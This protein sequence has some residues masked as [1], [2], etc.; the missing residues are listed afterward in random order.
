MGISSSSSAPVHIK[1]KSCIR[2]LEF[3]ILFRPLIQL[4][5]TNLTVMQELDPTGNL[6]LVQILVIA[7]IGMIW[8]A[9]YMLRTDGKELGPVQIR[10]VALKTFRIYFQMS[11]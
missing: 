8:K 11:K 5:L 1:E 3:I 6:V 7:L 2:N 9:M 10:G 4:N